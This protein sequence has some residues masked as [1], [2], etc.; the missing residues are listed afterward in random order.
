[1]SPF[2]LESAQKRRPPL[3]PITNCVRYVTCNSPSRVMN[4]VVGWG[5]CYQIA[6]C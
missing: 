2:S 6:A 3:L 4:C 5:C 1:M